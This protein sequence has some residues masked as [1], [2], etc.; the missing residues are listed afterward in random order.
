MNIALFSLVL[1]ACAVALCASGR[2]EPAHEQPR[3]QQCYSTGETRDKI[4]DNEI[5]EP[6]RA[7]QKAAAHFE[8]E[9]LSAKLCRLRDVFVY[10]IS[11]LRRDG[12]LIRCFVDAKSGQIV[13]IHNEKK[14]ED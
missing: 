9:A 6:F 12:R 1:A 3:E 13:E 4:A 5:G 8:A 2:A 10:E 14:R 11:L 7:M